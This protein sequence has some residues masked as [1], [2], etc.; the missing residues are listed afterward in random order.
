M[1]SLL[2]VFGATLV[3]SILQQTAYTHHSN[4]HSGHA[5]SGHAH[6]GQAH[7]G[8]AHSRR[9]HSRRAHSRHNH[10]DGVHSRRTHNRHIHNG[11]TH[12]V[13][14]NPDPSDKDSSRDS[15]Q[16]SPLRDHYQYHHYSDIG[17][18]SDY[19]EYW[20]YDGDYDQPESPAHYHLL[21]GG[22]YMS[23]GVMITPHPLNPK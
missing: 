1:A 23:A 9:A 17:D 2:L 6:S 14:L 3:L 10:K 19:T 22:E 20:D 18:H 15:R 4:T 7:S 16:H 8:H 11:R 5:H 21:H 13:H 12:F